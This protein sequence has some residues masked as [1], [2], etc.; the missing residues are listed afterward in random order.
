MG[1]ALL[2]PPTVEGWHT[3][4]EWID[5]GTLNERVNFAVNQLSDPQKPGIAA[6]IS[7]LEKDGGSLTPDKFVDSCITLLGPFNVSGET[8]SG[9]IEYARKGGDL[10][11][12]TDKDRTEG[13][14]RTVRMLQAIVSSIEY[15]FA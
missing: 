3:G 6:L 8:R 4:R 15:Q 9:L 11:F 1:Q 2:T 7:R 10:K 13:A 12:A 5:G 14:A